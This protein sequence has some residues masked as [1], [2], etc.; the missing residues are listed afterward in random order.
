MGATLSFK[1]LFKKLAEYVLDPER[2]WDYCVRAK[3]GQMDTSIPG[4]YSSLRDYIMLSKSML[5]GN[6]INVIYFLN[7]IIRK[8]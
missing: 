6:V 5:L 8:I 3:R 2:R 1:D 7:D 4:E